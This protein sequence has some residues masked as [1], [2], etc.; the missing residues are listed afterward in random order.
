[1][2][3]DRYH[4]INIYID[5][6]PIFSSN[7]FVVM[8]SSQLFSQQ[9]FHCITVSTCMNDCVNLTKFRVKTVKT[10]YCII[11]PRYLI[12]KQNPYTKNIKVKCISNV[13]QMYIYTNC[14]TEN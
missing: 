8:D 4:Q 6:A 9:C 13:Y 7:I 14:L 11:I 1:M 12:H 3:I 5:A 2:N 10:I